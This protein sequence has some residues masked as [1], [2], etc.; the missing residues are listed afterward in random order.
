[1]RSRKNRIYKSLRSSRKSLRR[2]RKSLRRSRK[3][4]R[5]NRKSLIGGAFD[6]RP[7]ELQY[8]FDMDNTNYSLLSLNDQAYKK[9]RMEKDL[10]E[11]IMTYFFDAMNI[12][13]KDLNTPK[14]D[15][16][17]L[18]KHMLKFKLKEGEGEFKHLSDLLDLPKSSG[19]Y[20][21][22]D[23]I[24]NSIIGKHD[25]IDYWSPKSGAYDKMGKH[26]LEEF[27][28]ILTQCL[29][30]LFIKNTGLEHPYMSTNP[31]SELRKYGAQ[32][33]D[34]KIDELLEM[35]WLEQK[36]IN[37]IYICGENN[38]FNVIVT[39]KYIDSTFSSFP[40]KFIVKDNGYCLFNSL[41]L[42]KF[43]KKNLS[44]DN[45]INDVYLKDLVKGTHYDFVYEFINNI[46]D[47]IIYK[48]LKLFNGVKP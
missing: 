9:K 1:M 34:A 25:S 43:F 31:N 12:D 45:K 2:S 13:Y 11:R 46:N 35:K 24:Y 27:I 42:Y 10:K 6:F 4:L 48:N 37:P 3:S 20:T 36:D 17:K 40:I 26:G 32:V 15:F 33:C 23:R 30:E 38:H 14:D 21:N 18:L 44:E 16:K 39:T 29:V 41:A 5:R 28:R 47:L 7:N 19:G 22:F 8:F